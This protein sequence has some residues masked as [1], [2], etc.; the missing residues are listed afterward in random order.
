MRTN[1][2][3]LNGLGTRQLVFCAAKGTIEIKPLENPTASQEDDL[4]V[5]LTLLKAC[6]IG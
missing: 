6:G 3:E 1:S 2:V 4:T 5:H